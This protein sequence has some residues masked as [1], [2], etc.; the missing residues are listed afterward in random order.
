MI[1]ATLAAALLFACAVRPASADAGWFEQG[2][3]S[4]R[5]DLQLLNDAGVI[6][7]PVNQWPLPRAAVRYAIENGKT[8]IANN[9]AVM[10]ALE[11][12]RTRLETAAPAKRGVLGLEAWLSAGEPGLLRDFDTVG[13]ENAEVHGRARYSVGERAEFSLNFGAV[14]DPAD[15]EEFR[16]D[17]SHATVELGNWLLSANTLDRWWGPGHEGSLILSNNARPMPTLMVERASARPFESRWLNWLGPWTMNFGISRMESERED[18]DAPLFMAWRVALMPFKDI[19]IGL[20]RTAQFCGEQLE[21][22]WDVFRNMLIGNDNVGIDTTPETE[23]GN[24]MAGFDLRWNS[25]IGSWPYAIY[26]QLIG[27]D[28]SSYVPAKY[29][30]QY[31]V[32]VWKPMTNGGLV[33]VFTEYSTTTCSANTDRGPYYGCA[34]NQ[35]LFNVEGYRYR[36]RVIGHSAD[37]DAENYALGATF[38]MPDGELWSVTARSS[39]L[40]R[41]GDG[42]LRN[43]VAADPTDYVAL[44][45]GWRGMVFG[46]QR[47]DVD[48]GVDS[49]E[50]VGG[51][52]RDVH[53]FGFIRWN[54]S[55]AP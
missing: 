33:Q 5:K 4:L 36:D 30:S 23:P 13:R 16:L 27:E 45:L 40:H 38:T 46:E 15:G 55:F 28:E 26:S 22:S 19:E 2:D 48:L 14:A 43:T 11:R 24:Q 25:P 53:A 41:N 32:E 18:I 6:R 35:G 7:L 29:I 17:G 44:E 37:R 51:G 31:G 3:T 34:Y 8:R 50:L 39:R 47:F 1:R 42:D 12:V 9:A 10:A 20:S 52:E 54:Y 21:C 49:R